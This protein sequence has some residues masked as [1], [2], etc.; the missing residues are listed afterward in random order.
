MHLEADAVA[1]AVEE[2]LLEN[3]ARR[4]RELRLVAV[5]LEELADDAMR[6]RALDAGSDRRVREIERLA[7]ERVVAGELVGNLPETERPRHVRVAPGGRVA[8]EQVDDDRLVFADGAVAGLVPDRR[9]RARRDEDDVVDEHALLAEDVHGVGLEVLAG[10][11]IARPQALADGA[12]RALGRALAAPDPVELGRRLHPPALVEELAAGLDLDLVG[13]QEVGEAER[14]VARR[15]GRGDVG[16]A[17]GPED[18][19]GRHV[20]P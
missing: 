11:R 10:D 15:D 16:R 12:H 9:L 8:R 18:E 7:H 3:L 2:A 20:V 4:L 1:E 13:T 17:A 5:L 19:L 14:K 6:L